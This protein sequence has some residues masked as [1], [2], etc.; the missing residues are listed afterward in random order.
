[1][2]RPPTSVNEDNFRKVKETVFENHPVGS[3]EIAEDL[4]IFYGYTLQI[5]VNVLGI[6]CVNAGLVPINLNL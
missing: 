2:S 4:N 5:L 6:K 3:R 1:M